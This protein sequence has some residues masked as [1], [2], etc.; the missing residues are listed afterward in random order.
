M[1]AGRLAVREASAKFAIF[2]DGMRLKDFFRALMIVIAV[3]G[4]ARLPGRPASAAELMASAVSHLNGYTLTYTGT[5][6][7]GGANVQIVLRGLS[8]S[9]SSLALGAATAGSD[10]TFQG[11]VSLRCAPLGGA[12]RQLATVAALLAPSDPPIATAKVSFSC[13]L[14]R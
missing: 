12:V 6:F 7:A 13:L 8:G 5:N 3:S 11:I 1:R 4:S 9:A 14:Q 10:G 2:G